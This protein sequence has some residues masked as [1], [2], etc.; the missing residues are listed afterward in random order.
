[1]GY[2]FCRYLNNGFKMDFDF[3]YIKN[4]ELKWIYLDIY[5]EF[6]F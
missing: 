1:M 2:K 4:I 6:Y 3:F 5:L